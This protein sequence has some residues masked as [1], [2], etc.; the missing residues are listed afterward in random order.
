MG[1][2]LKIKSTTGKIYLDFGEGFIDCTHALPLV[3]A[4]PFYRRACLVGSLI[5]KNGIEAFITSLRGVRGLGRSAGH[6]QAVDT[7]LLSES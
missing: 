2:H 7:G 1:K 4:A 3:A 5:D 6:D